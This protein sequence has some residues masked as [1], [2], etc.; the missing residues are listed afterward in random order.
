MFLR[1]KPW[2]YGSYRER[3]RALNLF[4]IK[5]RLLC[6]TL[7]KY[8]S[9]LCDEARVCDLSELFVRSPSSRTRGHRFKLLAP[10]CSTDILHTFFIVGFV[11]SIFGIHSLQLLLRICLFPL[12]IVLWQI[13]WVIHCLTSYWFGG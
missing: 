11:V 10:L 7:I 6:A 9:I 2:F 1:N 4:S 8:W 13:F 12:L 3:L 5:G